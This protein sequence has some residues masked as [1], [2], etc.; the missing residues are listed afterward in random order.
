MVRLPEHTTGWD[1]ARMEALSWLNIFVGAVVYGGAFLFDLPAW[2]FW[3]AVVAGGVI[4]ALEIF[5]E[6]AEQRGLG[7]EVVGPESVVL[8]AGLW[9]AGTALVAGGP[10]TFVAIAFVGGLLVAVTSATNLVAS[11]RMDETTGYE[12]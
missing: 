4:I 11:Y 3:T 7:R 5:D 10:G 9:L 2:T 8:V 12:D 1:V 6:W